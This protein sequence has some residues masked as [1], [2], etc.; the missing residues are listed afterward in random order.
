MKILIILTKTNSAKRFK[1]YL[2]VVEQ[3]EHQIF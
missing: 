1:V 3:L 2:Q